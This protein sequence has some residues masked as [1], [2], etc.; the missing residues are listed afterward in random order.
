[1]QVFYLIIILIYTILGQ[2]VLTKWEWNYN[3]YINPIFW[4]ILSFIIMLSMPK[5][6]INKNKEVKLLQYFF[7]ATLFYIII[8]LLSGLLV[9]FGDNPYSS[10]F[11]GLLTNIWIT[12]IPILGREFA[13]YAIVSN[14]NRKNRE[15]IKI[16]VI[17][18]F[19]LI[20]FNIFKMIP[21]MTSITVIFKQFVL[22]II[23]TIIKNCLYTQIVQKYSYKSA[24]I[25]EMG[26]KLFLWISPILPNTPWILVAILD[27][28]VP[29]ILLIYVNNLIEND[30]RIALKRGGEK[31][32]TKH[33][34]IFGGLLIVA[35]CFLVGIF[36]IHLRAVATGSMYPEINVG[37]AVLV[38]KI[39]I[40]DLKVG[41][42]IE[43]QIED[44]Y[45]IHRIINKEEKNG[46][47][48]LEMKGDNNKSSDAKLVYAEQIQG[49]V[50]YKIKY[51][52]FPSYWLNKLINSKDTVL[53][54]TGN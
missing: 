7:I 49:K 46:V 38:K 30:N 34:I 13:R 37:D 48:E 1:M 36:P 18:I 24:W 50:I 39:D 42:I 40:K 51:I 4:I 52:G 2:S 32:D 10:E 23:P 29:L 6:I 53:V 41:D 22:N 27:I 16:F 28:T 17:I 5:K 45:V 54:E 35:A 19:S 31:Q 3:N 33:I 14:S 12:A 26:I 47:W 43:Y 8:Y 9:T 44:Q 21:Q 15:K 20:E 25:Y 11:K